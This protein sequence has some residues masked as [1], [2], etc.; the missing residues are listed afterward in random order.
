VAEAQGAGRGSRGRS[1]SSPPGGLWMSV[2]ARPAAAA[3]E[4]VSLRAGL[5]VLECLD[6]MDA[7][8]AVRLKWPNDLMLGERKAGGILCEARWHGQDLAW[9]VIGLGLN[10]ANAP[11]EELEQVAASLTS[12]RP[13]L[14]PTELAEPAVRA[15]RAVDAAGGA[16]TDEELARFAKR[17]WLRG[18]ALAAPV[19]GTADGIAGDGTLRVVGFDGTVTAVRAGTIVLA[20]T[21]ATAGP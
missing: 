16:L 17:D 3:L 20:T 18:R 14:R 1:W 21:S 9:V 5:A 6:A 7:G 2:L 10:V 12:I 15:L 11:P 4:L 8:H 13:G 19:L